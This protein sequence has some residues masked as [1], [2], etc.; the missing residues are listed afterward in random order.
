M[1][2]RARHSLAVAVVAAAACG[3]PAAAPADGGEL[4]ARP[5]DAAAQ[6]T[7]PACSPPF[8]TADL[9][10]PGVTADQ[11]TLAYW[12]DRLGQSADLDR[13]VLT[14]E[15]VDR[16]D[17]AIAIPRD[18]Y[19]PQRDLLA[20][21]DLDALARKVQERR[22][23]A[24]DRI[25]GG[26][27]VA[28]DGTPV[29][30]G[31]RRAI[32]ADVSLAA[33]R[34]TLRVALADLL[35][36]CTPIPQP[37]LP[38]SLD[39]RLDRNA[40]STVR[41]QDGVR[42]VARWPNG[43]WLVETRLSFGWISG[44]APLSPPVP[45]PVRAAYERGPRVE[46][47]APIAV[48]NLRIA[49]GTV[50]PAADRRGRRAYVATRTGFV[51]TPAA[52]ARSLRPTRRSVTRRAVLERA[53]QFVGRP[54]GLG[55]AA[56]GLDCSRLLVDV[57]ESFGLHLPRHSAWQSRAGSFWID[58]A[59]A[60]DADKLRLIDTA[61]AK[62]IALL[63]F[64]G[65]IMLYL[66]R[67]HRGV[68][69]VLHA[70]G[71]YAERCDGGSDRVVRVPAVT[72]S[73][74]DLGR[75]SGRRSLLERITRIT[76]IGGSPGPELR[77]VA[78]FRP[79]PAPAI[80]KDRAC[81]DSRRAAIYAMPERPNADQPLRIVAALDRDPGPATLALVDPTG[82]RVD[83]GVVH[84]GGPPFGLV[85]TVPRPRRGTWKAVVADGDDVIACQRV[86]VAG[87]RPVPAEPNDGPVWEPEYA[88]HVG[89]ENLFALWVERLFDY[90]VD[91]DRVWPDLHSLL[92]DPARN[93]LYD[94]RGLGEDELIELGPD[95][96]DLPYTLRAY[97]AWKMRLPFRYR[98]CK[99]ARPGKPPDCSLPGGGDNLMSRLEL[100]GKDGQMVPRDDVTAFSLFINYHVSRAVHSSSGR[101]HPEDELTDFYPVPLTRRA[102]KPGTLFADPYGHLM[103]VADWIPQGLDRYGVLVAADAQPDGTVGRRRFW[104]GSFLF[105]PDV[106]SGG[107]GF[108][109][110]RPIVFVPEP[111][112]VPLGSGPLWITA[113][114]AEAREEVEAA[115]ARGV[116]PANGADSSGVQPVAVAPRAAGAPAASS[117]RGTPP[118]AAGG[119]SAATGGRASP[120]GAGSP[121]WTGGVDDAPDAGATVGG[122]PPELPWVHRIGRYREIG[123]EELAKTRRYTRFSLQQYRGSA[124]DFYR[125]VEGLINPRPLDPVARQRALVD[126]LMEAVSR[127]VTSIANGEEFMATHREIVPMPEGAAIFLTSGPWE[128][129]STP[130]RDLRLLI[131]I[132]SVVRFP[133]E[134]RAEPHRFGLRP[135]EVDER[136]AQLRAVLD[137][138]LA[139]RS[140]S[141]VR[142]DGSTWTL[143][144]ADVVERAEKFEMAYNPNDCVEIR[145]GAAADTE[146]MA[147][148]R[149]H[150][151]D[152]QRARMEAL[153]GW[154]RTRKR[155]P[156]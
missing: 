67:D 115:A 137:R 41:A 25:D 93:L 146:E 148:C 143:S 76:V 5:A 107:A 60:S 149:R 70:L 68:P 87:R 15:E 124:D 3:K 151:P 55:G 30:D 66:G 111:A 84:L 45:A 19:Y 44:D 10:L 51:R 20:P 56:G 77:G 53:W 1:G 16:L 96:A 90:P 6:A 133:D 112:D 39:P 140:F 113:E 80:P 46:T 8:R 82:R 119:S 38:P 79:T 35:V 27:W 135:D 132:D 75:G 48:G 105:D 40:C 28:A 36:R 71:E 59:G 136:V 12:L 37:L 18:G 73:G 116:A 109:T 83:A 54:Y 9:P 49:A 139:A 99:R 21:A 58:V 104:R 89:N 126:A 154:F 34:P 94:Y 145:W 17:A 85:A 120:S 118:G 117:G 156:N 88:W 23:W 33:A 74:L 91:E 32:D 43:M 29:G 147:T 100:R 130:S 50:L 114:E 142:S 128:D 61:A 31:A 47:T 11:L 108:K 98:R 123:N 26:E 95:C 152:D 102:L 64:P 150:A 81:H 141:Y 4:A 63:H 144:L 153:R 131:A 22:A 7:P 125:T 2:S 62:G 57:F 121:P 78:T 122:G 69:R 65:H 13:P 24:R 52:A 72:V 138:E 97:F 101:T 103:V 110:F 106:T 129:Y 86:R 42:V 155:P 127:R 92:R 14:P 134:V